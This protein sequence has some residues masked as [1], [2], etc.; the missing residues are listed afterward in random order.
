MKG[1]RERRREGEEEEVRRRIKRIGR[2]RIRKK[3]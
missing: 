2:P 3:H 1:L